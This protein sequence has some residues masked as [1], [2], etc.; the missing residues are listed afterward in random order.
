MPRWR[1]DPNKFYH[2]DI[3]RPGSIN[4]TGGYFIQEDTRQ[5]EPS[6]FGIN[7]LEAMSMDPQQR[8]LLEV[9][10]EC[11]ESAGA[12]LEQLSGADVGCYVAN[13]ALDFPIIQLHDP[14][15][16]NRYT[17]VGA[18]PNI[19]AN[20]VSHIFNLK[21]PSVVMDTACSSSLYALHIACTALDAGECRSA[22]VA[23]ANLVQAPQFQML[24]TRAGI[25]SSSSTCRTFDAAADGY[26]R[27]D[28]VGSLYLKRLSDAIKDKDPIR[29]VIR[30]S[31]VNA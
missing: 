4:S 17:A 21:G 15:Y 19:L 25:L 12:S 9:V 6:F 11:F 13:F 1:Y 28:G 26:G 27:A 7:N 30:G 31:A 16:I 8:K 5:F 14:E 10:F 20:R 2:P 18:A 23:S 24:A 22:I 3:D 29:A